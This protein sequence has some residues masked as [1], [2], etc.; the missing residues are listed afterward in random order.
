MADETSRTAVIAGLNDVMFSND[1]VVAPGNSFADINRNQWNTHLPG[2]SLEGSN[3]E[4]GTDLLQAYGL[5]LTDSN[6]QLTGTI[7]REFLTSTEDGKTY[8]QFKYTGDFAGQSID[9]VLGAKF[10]YTATDLTNGRVVTDSVKIKTTSGEP[11]VLQYR[12]NLADRAQA[13]S[14]ITYKLSQGTKVTSEHRAAVTVEEDNL[15]TGAALKRAYHMNPANTSAQLRGSITRTFVSELDEQG[16]LQGHFEYSGSFGGESMTI[17]SGTSFTAAQIANGAQVTDTVEIKTASGN[18]LVM[19]YTNDLTNLSQM[20]SQIVYKNSDKSVAASTSSAS[21]G[22]ASV[23]QDN[24]GNFEMQRSQGRNF[25]VQNA[26]LSGSVTRT[27]VKDSDTEGHFEYSGTFAGKDIET[28][29]GGKF[30]IPV[31]TR[32][33][34][35]M[36]DTISIV[37]S[38]GTAMAVSFQNN[39]LNLSD[40]TAD[41]SFRASDYAY[42]DFT[43]DEKITNNVNGSA[44]FT[45]ITINA[46]MRELFI[47]SNVEAGEGITMKWENLSNA[48][49]G[50]AGSNVLT[51]ESAGAANRQIKKAMKM[52]SKQRSDFG[53]Y[54]NRLE[55]AKKI[56]DN[57]GENTQA[58][59]SR[60]RDADMAQE[61]L[62]FAKQNILEQAAQTMLSQA[63]QTPQGVLSLLQ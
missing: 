54:Q 45:D 1:G 9:T 19:K 34:T 42:R 41:L 17:V 33:S 29:S 44:I 46:P 14:Q 56:D 31:D 2:I 28:K 60:I 58:A 62:E 23:V 20:T 53:A 49:L 61:M 48:A 47:H 36:T 25:N 4:I 3:L 37:N 21:S 63:N 11:L 15:D 39:L 57:V 59:E 30:S 7:S 35:Y 12:N 55:H 26:T 22:S 43:A 6:A 13:E 50:I 8:G 52:V 16:D 5:D 51:A 40:I 32:Y 27:F 24:M 18:P 10:E 38:A